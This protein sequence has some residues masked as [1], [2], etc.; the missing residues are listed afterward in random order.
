M[1]S[2]STPVEVEVPVT[3][4]RAEYDQTRR[5]F[6]N[7]TGMPRNDKALPK[8]YPEGSVVARRVTGV[9][10]GGRA[11]TDAPAEDYSLPPDAW[12]MSDAQVAADEQS[13]YPRVLLRQ[14][15]DQDW[16]ASPQ[17]VLFN[18][19]MIARLMQRTAPLDGAAYKGYPAGHV[20]VTWQSDGRYLAYVFY[21][22][23]KRQVYFT[24]AQLDPIDSR[25]ATVESTIRFLA[26]QSIGGLDF[27]R[28]EL[29][30]LVPGGI[31]VAR[32]YDQMIAMARPAWYFV[33]RDYFPNGS[34]DVPDVPHPVN[35]YIHSAS[36]YPT[37]VI[38]P[39]PDN[40][41]ADRQLQRK[42]TGQDDRTDAWWYET[43]WGRE[44]VVEWAPPLVRGALKAWWP[45]KALDLQVEDWVLVRHP[46]PYLPDPRDADGSLIDVNTMEF[47][48]VAMRE[49]EGDPLLTYQM[50]RVRAKRLF[51][52]DMKG[53]RTETFPFLT[54]K[55]F[56]GRF[57]Y[58]HKDDSLETALIISGIA[59]IVV[60]GIVVVVLTAGAAA[61]VE[62]AAIG[63]VGGAGGAGAGAG[64][65]AAGAAT[66]AEATVAA[67]AAV[68][69]SAA[70]GAGATG[71]AAATAGAAAVAAAAAEAAVAVGG[72]TAAGAGAAAAAGAASSAAAG[73]ASGAIAAS[74]ASEG[75]A[76]VASA[77][78]EAAAAVSAGGASALTVGEVVA[79]ASAV[80][81][82]GIKVAQA[83]E[84]QDAQRS[85][86][87]QAVVQAANQ[88]ALDQAN[89]Q[90]A[91]AALDAASQVPQPPS[92]SGLGAIL[93]N[94]LTWIA[95]LAI[96]AG[97]GG[98]RR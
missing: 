60:A 23:Y 2:W 14:W 39:E 79:V 63:T 3:L 36:A 17:G 31:D 46:H 87:F 24:D 86:H 70:A 8:V 49:F 80:A 96:A 28:T 27:F 4:S 65:A 61:P 35:Q 40:W 92:V 75:A 9:E 72:S 67:S 26:L 30:R 82:T 41:V 29:A 76:I 57:V 88:A 81:G 52:P 33:K 47:V 15:L 95:V 22:G 38:L 62:A 43:P 50:R 20:P 85:S 64:A 74:G 44:R 51:M 97:T 53:L 10:P 68:G 37:S 91:Q 1:G 93:R 56:V 18:D 54:D 94:P 78:A 89:L 71:V 66:V 98:R 48:N 11:L 59:L 16:S 13:A 69:A 55:G 12:Y 90:A 32:Y 19:F 21:S 5:R 84:Q 73:I 25:F 7:M 42:N 58:H 77:A 34:A 83:V 6:Y 45:A